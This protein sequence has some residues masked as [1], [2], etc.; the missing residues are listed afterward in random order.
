MTKERRRWKAA[1]AAKRRGNKKSG[2][3]ENNVEKSLAVSPIFCH[4]MI[5]IDRWNLW[6]TGPVLVGSGETLEEPKG[7]CDP[8]GKNLLYPN[9]LFDVSSAQDTL[10]AYLEHNHLQEDPNT[11]HRSE[12][13]VSLRMTP[14]L[15]KD[16]KQ[17]RL[18]EFE[19]LTSTDKEKLATLTTVEYLKTQLV[20]LRARYPFLRRLAEPTWAGRKPEL[21]EDLAKHHKCLIAKERGYKSRVKSQLLCTA[22]L[23]TGFACP[24]KKKEE[25]KLMFYS[26]TDEAKQHFIDKKY[27]VESDSSDGND[28]CTD[29]DDE[30]DGP[31]TDIEL[32]DEESRTV[33]TPDR[34][35]RNINM[36]A[37]PFMERPPRMSL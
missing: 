21:A 23:G 35:Q 29:S 15:L 14:A 20:Q 26:L 25:L 5:L 17:A 30:E 36:V 1:A 31:G 2:I 9:L 18:D 10:M 4:Q 33:L 6:G 34:G 19:R 8:S 7:F 13:A 3:Q 24:N 32:V 12:K 16:V 27:K 22:E 11:V 28:G 37:T